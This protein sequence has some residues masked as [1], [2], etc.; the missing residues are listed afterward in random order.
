V[1]SSAGTST[2]FQM[3]SSP[4]HFLSNVI[5]LQKKMLDIILHRL[6]SSYFVK[7]LRWNIRSDL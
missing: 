3:H 7:P 5:F 6:V 2:R 1:V 4:I